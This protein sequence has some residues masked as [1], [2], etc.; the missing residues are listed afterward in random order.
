MEQASGLTR[1]LP[2]VRQRTMKGTLFLNSP[3]SSSST[4]LLVPRDTEDPITKV[5]RKESP[6]EVCTRAILAKTG[7]RVPEAD[8]QACHALG[9]PGAS[10]NT[11]YILRFANMKPG[12]AWDVLSAGLLTG[13]N[14]VTKE[15]FDSQVPLFIN[16]QLSKNKTQLTKVVRDSKKSRRISKYGVDQNGRITVKVT[17]D[18][19]WVE[20]TSEEQLTSLV[21]AAPP[22]ATV[23]RRRSYGQRR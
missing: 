22:P 13:R 4:S 21:M 19:A 20:V 2:S 11:S 7:V 1:L 8:L 18:S 17:P 16:F 3:H 5:R 9:R 14:K 23:S 6:V 15:N 10:P 12:S